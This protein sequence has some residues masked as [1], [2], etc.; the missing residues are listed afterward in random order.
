MNKHEK[1]NHYTSAKDVEMF[2][3]LYI[4]HIVLDTS[5]I[6]TLTA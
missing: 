1:G 5:A 4:E 3:S 6:E 2:S